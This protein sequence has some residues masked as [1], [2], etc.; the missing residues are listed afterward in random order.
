MV[1]VMVRW[2]W[3]SEC[4]TGVWVG[5]GIGM[6][7]VQSQ[8][9]DCSP[10]IWV[11][12]WDDWG[13]WDENNE[14]NLHS[15]LTVFEVEKEFGKYAIQWRKSDFCGHICRFGD[16]DGARLV[17]ALAV[18]NAVMR[19]WGTI[20]F[21]AYRFW[22]WKRFCIDRWR[23][24]IALLFSHLHIVVRWWWWWCWCCSWRC[25]WWCWWGCWL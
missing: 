22:S 11:G 8:W 7:F 14:G 1:M 16:G 4:S 23:E 18:I 20:H 13:I 12:E 17:A 5:W 9:F 6:N 25:W 21:I 10:E 24:E 3:C 19:S 2:W 15:S